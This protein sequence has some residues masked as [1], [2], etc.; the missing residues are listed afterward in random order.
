LCCV[1]PGIGRPGLALTFQKIRDSFAS[2]EDI[3]DSFETNPS[4]RIE[5]VVPG[6]E[7]PF[8]GN[9][10]ALEIGFQKIRTQCGHFDGWIKTLEMRA[11]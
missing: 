5:D 6:Y 4:K 3:N 2:P 9:L 11:R 8:L 1:C 10:A 7:K